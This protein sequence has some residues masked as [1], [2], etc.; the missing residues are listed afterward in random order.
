MPETKPGALAE[1]YQTAVPPPFSAILQL[2]SPVDTPSNPDARFVGW[3]QSN[4]EPL[5]GWDQI[6]RLQQLTTA[7]CIVNMN[8]H[9]YADNSTSDQMKPR[10]TSVALSI[11]LGYFSLS[12]FRWCK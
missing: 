1:T 6:S 8:D 11:F 2:S 10:R 12:D 3:V 7:A 5:G 9:S 4:G